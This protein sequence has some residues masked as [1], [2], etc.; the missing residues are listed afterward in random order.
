MDPELKRQLEE[1]HALAK[2][3]HHL[4]RALRRHQL[5][6]TFSKIAFWTILFGS[7]A[8]WY[9]TYLQPL[10]SR[11]QA[12]PGAATSDLFGFPSSAEL[13][14]LINSYKAGQ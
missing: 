4:L 11:F 9:Q 10:I 2:D 6:G 5:I 1:I 14:K 8:Y 3:N 7:S 13:Q 12:T